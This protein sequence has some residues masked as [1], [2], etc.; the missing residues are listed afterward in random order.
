V[1]LQLDRLGLVHPNGHRALQRVSLS[2]AAGARVA[3]I[4]PSGAGKTSLLRLAAASLR[5]TEGRIETLG[6]NPWQLSANGLKRLRARV[7]LTRG[8]RELLRGLARD[9]ELARLRVHANGADLVPRDAA[10]PADEG[11]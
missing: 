1:S 3:V 5:P 6:A 7:G 8:E 2:L 4:G 11:Q 9:L 10:A